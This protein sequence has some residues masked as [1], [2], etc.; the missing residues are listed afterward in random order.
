MAFPV[1]ESKIIVAEALLGLRFPE[2]HRARLLRDNGGEVEVSV[3]G[4]RLDSPLLLFPVWDDS[5][6]K[7]QGRTANHVVMESARASDAAGF[8][9]AAVAIAGVD[10]DYLVILRDGPGLFFWSHET[11]QLL[12]AVVD[13]GA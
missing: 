13:W 7:R 2:E 6:R 12:P 10:G 8:P 9:E 1:E 11:G 5:D 3:D 4:E